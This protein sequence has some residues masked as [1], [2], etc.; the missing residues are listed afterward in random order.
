MKNLRIH[1]CTNGLL[2]ILMIALLATACNKADLPTND[3]TTVNLTNL[4]QKLTDNPNF[5]A[6]IKL[7]QQIG[8]DLMILL[9]NSEVDRSNEEVVVASLT[10][11]YTVSEAE[12]ARY[13]T[14]VF[15]ELP[16][17][18]TISEQALE[19]VL[20]SA[21]NALSQQALSARNCSD[22]YRHCARAAYMKY[23][24]G[25]YDYYAYYTQQTYCVYEYYRC[26]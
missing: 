5:Q 7:H 25:Y 3:P 13:K 4:A 9:K 11:S 14:K 18:K 16:E 23:Y 21:Q 6:S 20:T 17:L 19:E 22:I 1:D 8:N 15:N 10:K 24:Y 12:F 26:T 2:T